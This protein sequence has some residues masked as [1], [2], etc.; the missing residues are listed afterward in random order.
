MYFSRHYNI[1][2][3]PSPTVTTPTRNLF[4]GELYSS[5][6][7]ELMHRHVIQF[8]SICCVYFVVA[9]FLESWCFSIDCS[10]IE[11]PMIAVYNT[12]AVIGPV[13]FDLPFT[14]YRSNDTELYYKLMIVE[15]RDGTVWKKYLGKL[16][17]DS[18]SNLC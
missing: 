1:R 9:R 7:S 13:L 18:F 17:E 11:N 5:I 4:I 12:P 6:T 14:S 15:R 16:T 2:P 3:S 10:A 8:C